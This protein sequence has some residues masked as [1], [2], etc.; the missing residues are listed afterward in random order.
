MRSLFDFMDRCDIT[1]LSIAYNFRTCKFQLRGA[2]EWDNSIDFSL[3]NKSFFSS[4]VYDDGT[5][6]GNMALMDMIRSYGVT[7]Y[8]EEI[9]DLMRTGRHESIKLYYYKKYNARFACFEHSTKRGNLNKYQA[10]TCGGIRRHSSSMPEKEVFVDGMNLGR[11]MT[12]KNLA[13][14]IPFGGCKVTLQV[15]ELDLQNLDLMGFIAYATDQVRAVTAPDMNLPAD[16]TDVILEEHLSSQYVGGKCSKTGTTGKPTAYGIFLSLKEAVRFKEGR[17]D[18]RGK[19][20][21]LIGLGAVGWNVGEYLLADG[22][23][24]VVCDI[25]D[26]RVNAFIREHSG[27]S[28][29]KVSK[30]TALNENVDIISPCAAGGVFDEETIN[31]LKCKYIWGSANNQLKATSK[32]E[33]IY[34][35]KKIK[36]KGILYQIEWW[37]N[38][39]GVICM[40]EEYLHDATQEQVLRKIEEIIPPSTW[41]N[42]MEADKKNITPTENCYAKSENVIYG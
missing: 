37:H 33:E 26:E 25:N 8:L 27:F 15:D 28:V 19:S 14:Q 36:E 41:E 39:A 6:Y 22:A 17:T 13:A 9:K 42:L 11:A 16:I 18:L 23:N 4:F 40:A 35:A 31:R 38:S 5:E 2:K 29:E 3:Y 21:L 24:L 1:H 10:K 30:G 32:D 12:F 7:E 34:L 20:V